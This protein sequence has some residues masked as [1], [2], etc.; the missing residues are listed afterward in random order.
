L[1][2]Q[3]IES[4]IAEKGWN[5]NEFYAAYKTANQGKPLPKA[6]ERQLQRI[7]QDKNPLPLTP[8]VKANLAAALGMTVEQLD[9]G[10]KES[11]TGPDDEK[12]R[13][14]ERR[15]QYIQGHPI[16]G[17][18]ILF[19]LK[20]AVGFDWFRELLDDI[21][22]GFSRDEP[23]F[24]VGQL[25]AS[26]SAPNTKESSH[27]VEEPVC[28][29]WEMYQPEPGYWFK[30]I[31]P[32]PHK[33]TTVAGF[34]AVMP[35]STLK[36]Q[37]VAKLQDFALLTKAGFS[38]P[39]RAYKVGVEEFEVRFF[40]DT[41]SFCMKL[42]DHELLDTL[43]EF[44]RQIKSE[45]LMT[46]GRSFSGVQLLEMFYQQMFPRPKNDNAKPRGG[47]GG[48][49]GPNGKAISFYPCMPTGFN[50]TPDS[51]EY[52]FKVTMPGEV[53]IGS[54]IKKLE[55]KLKSNPADAKSYGDLA[56]VYSHEGRLQDAIGCLET[57]LKRAPPDVYI[58]GLMAQILMNLGR[59]DEAL[60]HLQRAAALDP[61][62]ALIQTKL[63]ICLNELGEDD[64]ALI[65]FQAAASLENLNAGNQ[66]NLG[67]A[68]GRLKRNPEAAVA[69]QRA[70]DL[71]PE[72]VRSMTLLGIVLM[73]EGRQAEAVAFLEKATQLDPNFSNA[74]EHLGMYFTN[75]GQHE[76]AVASFQHAIA[77]EE[78]ALLNT[79][80]SASLASLDRWPE[81]EATCR[82][83]VELEPNHPDLLVNLAVAIAKLGKQ[84]EAVELCQSAIK[85][86]EDIRAYAVL[87]ESLS[88]LNRWAEA[89]AAYRYGLKL[90]PNH[91]AMLTNLGAAIATLG[92][93]PEA[94]ESFEQAVRADPANVTAQQN[95][96]QLRE[97][98]AKR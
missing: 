9:T 47:I 75:T 10:L 29:F 23:S 96:A 49:S 16:R 80:L 15:W 37:S 70:V 24:K 45:D 21:W 39:P 32:T 3:W 98:I 12:K 59:F 77:I 61:K 40:G 8:L 69:F 82:R 18:E 79:R 1:E 73:E 33:F 60:T 35:W 88:S 57:A 68:L 64:D 28:S 86:E 97:M 84:A 41:F 51:N 65:H 14:V 89:E 17:V 81:A 42:S 43:H 36:L 67:M 72:N 20:G 4:K 26:S 56:S 78:S 38:L 6:P 54:R 31:N 2:V 22:L 94:A 30:K 95:L 58:H 25:L 50:K 13:S 55:Q 85:I 11:V 46:F 90:E 62:H 92:R 34:D 76:K 91:S 53:D 5:K 27:S 19:I 87:G 7:F 52:T 66:F 48:M 93:L 63:G 74:H 44:A 83:A 71:E